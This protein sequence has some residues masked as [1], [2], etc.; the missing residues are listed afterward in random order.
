VIITLH[1]DRWI[2]KWGCEAEGWLAVVAEVT[3]AVT[4]PRVVVVFVVVVV[5][6]VVVVVVVVVVGGGCGGVLL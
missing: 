1:Y 3:C 4:V 5:V 6:M 2:A